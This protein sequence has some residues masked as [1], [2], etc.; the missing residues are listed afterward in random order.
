MATRGLGW[1]LLPV[2][3]CGVIGIGAAIILSS[4]GGDAGA[5]G[6]PAA[7]VD[8][9]DGARAYAN[10][11]AQVARG[12]RP[13]GSPASRRLAQ[14]L[15]TQLPDGRFEPLPGGLRNVVG[16]LPG[17][18]PAI[19]IGAHYDTKIVRDAP[20]FVGANDSAGGT[21]VVLELAHALAR[22]ERPAGAPE[23][24]FVLFDGEESPD[25][26][27]DFYAT[28]LRGSKAYAGAHAGELGAAIVVDFVGQ[29]DLRLAR[30]GGS[31]EQAWER[32]RSAASRAGV[33]GVFP[34]ETVGEVYDDH[35]PFARAGV[36][37]ID[38]IDFDYACF[39]RACDR[40]DQVDVR[41]LDATGEALVELLR[42]K[43]PI[44]FG[45]Q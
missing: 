12:P 15:R 32:L 3:L 26:E 8:R 42:Q 20:R 14:W 16:V 9:F 22:I 43:T 10:V 27:H 24:R 28:G 21:A 17:S 30:E 18:R 13:A 29:R 45:G 6:V 33:A 44:R 41:S 7:R 40:L 11:R 2:F 35:T 25:D 19:V 34:D 5:R 31:D 23:L 38:L 4:S 39:H 36:T 37:A 1:A